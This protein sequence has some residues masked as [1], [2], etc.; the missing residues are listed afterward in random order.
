MVLFHAGCGNHVSQIAVHTISAS[1]TTAAAACVTVKQPIE[2]C[3]ID[4]A[5]T[6]TAAAF[7]TLTAP[8]AAPCTPTAGAAGAAGAATCGSCSRGSGSGSVPVDTA[9]RVA[10]ALVVAAPAIACSFSYS[11]SQSSLHG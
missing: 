11:C 6:A 2:V 4:I 9:F 5:A 7:A 3:F 1:A 10:P 8:A